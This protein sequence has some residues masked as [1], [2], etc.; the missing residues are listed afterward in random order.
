MDSVAANFHVVFCNK[1]K[2]ESDMD[3]KIWTKWVQIWEYIR[4]NYNVRLRAK[5]QVD[6]IIIYYKI[7]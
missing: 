2:K 3:Y 6:I 1:T 7:N 5:A 4:I